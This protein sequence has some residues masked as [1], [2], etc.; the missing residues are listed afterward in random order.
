MSHDRGESFRFVSN[1]PLAQFYHVAVDDERPYNV[2]GGLQD[3]GSWRGP[4]HGLAEG[5]HPQPPLRGGGRRRRLRDAARSPRTRCTRLL[6]LA[7]RQPDALGP[8][9][10]RSRSWCKPAAARGHAA[11]LQLERRPR[12]RSRSSRTRSISA[13]SSCTARRDRGETWEPI[14]PRPDH[15]QPRVAEAGRERRP[16]ARRDRRRELHDHRHDRPQ[17]DRAGS[18]LDRHR[19]RPHARD[20][21]RR[22]DLDLG[23]EGRRRASRRTPGCR[24]SS[25]RASTRAR[26]SWC[27]TTTGAPTGRPTST[28]PTTTA[29]PGRASPRRSCA[30]Y[31]LALAQDAV[32][33]EL[34]FLGTEFGLYVSV[35][36][37][38]AWTHLKKAL[39]TASVMDLV[40][41]PARPRPGDRHPRPG[42]LHPRRHPPAARADGR[43]AGRAAAPLRAAPT[44]SSTGDA[45]RGRR[46]RLRRRRVPRREPALRRHPDLLAEPARPAGPGRRQGAGAQ[47]EGA[48]RSAPGGAGKDAKKDEKKDADEQEAEGR[49]R[50]RERAGPAWSA[51]SRRRPAWA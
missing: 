46:L 32:K 10:G 40:D 37:G 22:Q 2:Y 15:E 8:A 31:A 42:A 34:L 17:P 45:S 16:D 29:R 13:A 6:A 26:R 4:S 41:P 19:R 11:A 14:E 24:T 50:G 3:N 1:L 44:P 23:R 12:H 21:R 33:T 30:G 43:G 9:H 49:D 20:A 5:R 7:G 38:A 39:P 25:P 27:S 51:A 18:D 36:G 35:D 48:A 28:G 47:G